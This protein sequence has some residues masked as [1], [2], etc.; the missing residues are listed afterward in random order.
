MP[1][2]PS[3]LSAPAAILVGGEGGVRLRDRMRQ[4]GLGRGL[5]LPPAAEGVRLD[6]FEPILVALS[7]LVRHVLFQII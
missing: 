1:A 5:Q 7:L 3:K 4:H 2:A 6:E